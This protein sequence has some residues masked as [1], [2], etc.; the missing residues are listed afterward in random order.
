MNAQNKLHIDGYGTDE[1][2]IIMF[3][4]NRLTDPIRFRG[5]DVVVIDFNNYDIDVSALSEWA[6]DAEPGVYLIPFNVSGIWSFIHDALP[7]PARQA[8]YLA[9]KSDDGEYV[10][11]PN[12]TKARGDEQFQIS[13]EV[14][15][16]SV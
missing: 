12:F 16:D 5:G 7:E 4:M 9:Y 1:R 8:D 6:Q 13:E 11:Y 3:T 10:E 2:E 14:Y 15:H